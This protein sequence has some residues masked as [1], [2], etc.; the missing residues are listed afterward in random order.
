M[1]R[2][3]SF[4]DLPKDSMIKLIEAYKETPQ[5]VD[6]EPRDITRQV[7]DQAIG[8]LSTWLDARM[9]DL[10]RERVN[11]DEVQIIHR[12]GRTTIRVRGVDRYEFKL[13]I[14]YGSAG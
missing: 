13:K 7:M 3:K 14:S 6:W 11:L 5:F 8:T 10:I 4:A 9:A 12:G 1:T 2:I